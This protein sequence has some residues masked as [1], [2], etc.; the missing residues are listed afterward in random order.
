VKKAYVG[1]LYL[2]LAA[3]IWGGMYVVSKYA[4]DIIPPMT[5]LFI[6]YL[7]ASFVMGAI[8][9]S[10]NITI[11]PRKHRGLF[12]QI[13]FVGYFFSVGTQFIGTKLSSAHM[14]ALLTT[15]SPIFLSLFAILLL[16]EKMTSKQIIAMFLSLLGLLAIV[17][18][19]GIQGQ[20]HAL[21]G[22][23]I[24]LLAAISWGYYSVISRK[25][26]HYYSPIQITTVGIWIATCF[27]LP[28]TFF[29]VNQ[30][31]F[32][33]LFSWPIVLSTIYLG[34]ISTALAFFSWNK[35]LQLTP[36]HQA[37]IYFFL[38]PVVG[39]FFGWLLL[40]EHLSPSFF[41]GSL[42]ILTGVYISMNSSRVKILANKVE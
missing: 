23:F 32:T 42:F 40:H 17:G 34:I 4:L 16:K 36:S 26:S 28:T 8:C 41:I 11:I 21:L 38:Q 13:G 2:S 35:G 29:E 27:T 30:W 5:L 6:R 37:G 1:P 20:D 15:L 12:F 10:K 33:D 39:S 25:A 3:A 18:L 31:S 9:W 7:L 14:G 22:S 24:L 19:P